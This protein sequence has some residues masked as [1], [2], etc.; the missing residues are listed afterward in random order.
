MK[1][2]SENNLKPKVIELF[3]GMISPN[4]VLADFYS[5]NDMTK[6]LSDKIKVICKDEVPI[7]DFGEWDSRNGILSLKPEVIEGISMQT[8]TKEETK[9]ILLQQLLHVVSDR[10]NESGLNKYRLFKKD[11]KRRNGKAIDNGM[12]MGLAEKILGVKTN[13]YATEKGVYNVFSTLYGEEAFLS[14][15]ITGGDTV[16]EN[17]QENYG[18]TILKF[19]NLVVYNLDTIRSYEDKIRMCGKSA[20]KKSNIE[21]Y[22]AAKEECEGILDATLEKM[23]KRA[24]RL[25][26]DING[27]YD[28]LCKLKQSNYK[29]EIA[30]LNIQASIDETLAKIS[31]KLIEEGQIN[32][33]E[34]N[35]LIAT[36]E[37]GLTDIKKQA[38]NVRKLLI[39]Q[40]IEKSKG[41]IESRSY[42]KD[43][44]KSK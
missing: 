8:K 1:E 37:I 9:V 6:K 10:D 17:I 29:N 34:S 42:R 28:L 18:D 26:P 22:K 4:N 44:E 5:E 39:E 7:N 14:D 13:G 24:L 30:G 20:D 31:S 41:P 38:S 33:F 2:I 21:K 15:Y 12:S 25:T 27:K 16:Q 19:F 36:D 32:P 43:E 23:I 40:S 11:E 35:L 3:A